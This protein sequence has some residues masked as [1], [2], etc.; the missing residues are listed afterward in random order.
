MVRELLQHVGARFVLAV[1]KVCRD[2]DAL[3]RLTRPVLEGIFEREIDEPAN[4]LAVPDR[5]LPCDQRRDAHRLERGEQVADAAVRLVD[6][7]DEDEVRNAEFVERSQR[8]CR[9]GGTGR[10]GIHDDDRDIGDGERPCT[11]GG[12]ASG[13]SSVAS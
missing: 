4:L 9:E 3:G 11:V 2:F 5:Y 13:S 10:I 12:K 6:A 7:I 8:G 1:V